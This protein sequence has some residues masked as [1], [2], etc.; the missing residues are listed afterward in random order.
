MSVARTISITSFLNC[1][2]DSGA[3]CS[4]IPFFF[5][6]Q[7][8][9]VKTNHI[10]SKE[11]MLLKNDDFPEHFCHCTTKQGLNLFCQI[12]LLLQKKIKNR[13]Q[14]KKKKCERNLF[15]S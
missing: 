15:Q 12:F 5:F 10:P 4:K 6:N 2:R 8:Q 1:F 14:K 9:S 3:I 11:K 7:K 13:K